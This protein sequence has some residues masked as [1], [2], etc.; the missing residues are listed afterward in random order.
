M[1]EPN[2][3]AAL[4]RTGK[5]DRAAHDSNAVFARPTHVVVAGCTR[6]GITAT[7]RRYAS[8]TRCCAAWSAGRRPRISAAVPPLLLQI[9]SSTHRDLG[10]SA[11]A[12]RASLSCSP[13]CARRCKEP[14]R[15]PA[16]GPAL[17]NLQRG[18]HHAPLWSVSGA[19]HQPGFGGP[20]K[21]IQLPTAAVPGSLSSSRRRRLARLGWRHRDRPHWGGSRAGRSRGSRRR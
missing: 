1:T 5:R 12:D 11:W 17:P 20:R 2:W 16:P 4:S 8:V 7:W 15:D 9:A 10:G 19:A 6:E 14:S 13:P 18:S 21:C 3:R